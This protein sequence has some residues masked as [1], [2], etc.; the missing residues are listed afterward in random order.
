M[1]GQRGRL[2]AVPGRRRRSRRSAAGRRSGHASISTTSLSVGNHPIT[3]FFTSSNSDVSGS[4]GS[5]GGGQT[6]NAADTSTAVSSSANPSEYGGAVTLTAN[7]TVT[8]P[9]AGTA[10]GS[11]QFQDNGA[12][13]GAPQNVGGGGQAID[14]SRRVCPLAATRSLRHSQATARTS[15]TAARARTRSSTK[16]ARRSPTP[17]QHVRTTTTPLSSPRG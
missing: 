16:P 5:L 4:N 9:G 15:T 17:E 8:S 13:L 2:G 7:T 12:N 1:L 3:A 11:V 14:H 6:V 10:G